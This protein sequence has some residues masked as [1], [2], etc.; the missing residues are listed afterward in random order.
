MFPAFQFL[1]SANALTGSTRLPLTLLV[2]MQSTRS[3]ALSLKKNRSERTRAHDGLGRFG[4]HCFIPA[5]AGWGSCEVRA[6]GAVPVAAVHR[7]PLTGLAQKAG[8]WA[9]QGG[10]EVYGAIAALVDSPSAAHGSAEDVFAGARGDRMERD[11]KPMSR[12]MSSAGSYRD[13]RAVRAFAASKSPLLNRCW[14]P[15]PLVR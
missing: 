3:T 6:N 8:R 13:E 1:G 7:A 12:R 14:Q 5:R 10:G 9:F 4:R 11:G 15:A 2:R